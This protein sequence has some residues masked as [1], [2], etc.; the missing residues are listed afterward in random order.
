VQGL[1]WFGRS[2]NYQVFEYETRKV[3]D[4]TFDAG[5]ITLAVLA[6]KSVSAPN[7]GTPL[8]YTDNPMTLPYKAYQ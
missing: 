5:I 6:S 4:V 7:P 3:A 1:F 8:P 2:L